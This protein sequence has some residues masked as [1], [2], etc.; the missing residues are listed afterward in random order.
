MILVAE[1]IANDQRSG[2]PMAMLF[3]LNMLLATPEGDVFTLRE[4]RQWILEAGMKSVKSVKAPQASPL[5][6]ASK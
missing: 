5:V 3:G 4:I 6:L 1:F 2:P